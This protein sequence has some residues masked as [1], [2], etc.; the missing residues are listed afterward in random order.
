VKSGELAVT[1]R[2][3][4]DEHA[5]SVLADVCTAPEIID[6]DL[7]GLGDAIVHRVPVPLPDAS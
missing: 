6:T 7:P 1:S 4:T 2:V 5:A 3:A